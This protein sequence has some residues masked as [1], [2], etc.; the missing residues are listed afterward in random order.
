MYD[1]LYMYM[2]V[3]NNS[4][5]VPICILSYLF[6][7]YAYRLSLSL[8]SSSRC[9]D[10]DAKL[11]DIFRKLYIELVFKYFFSFF[12]CRYIINVI[13]YCSQINLLFIDVPLIYISSF[14]RTIV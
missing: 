2:V 10:I 9:Y 13:F 11:L 1:S 7:Q 4:L 12:F 8:F 3:T 6:I 14:R 5:Y